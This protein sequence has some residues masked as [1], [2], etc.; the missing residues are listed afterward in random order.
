MIVECILL[1]W[2][3][4]RIGHDEDKN[5]DLESLNFFASFDVCCNDVFRSSAIRGCVCV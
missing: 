1:I 3:T 5:K 2:V 4:I